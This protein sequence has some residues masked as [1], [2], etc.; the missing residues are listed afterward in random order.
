MR[1]FLLIIAV[2]TTWGAAFADETPSRRAVLPPSYEEVDGIAAVAGDK[3]VTISELRRAEGSHQS[4]QQLVPTDAERPRSKGALRLQTLQSL[5]DNLLV[6]KA[7]KDLGLTADDDDVQA[8]LE[9]TKKRT[10]WTDEELEENVKRLGFSNLAAYKT[11][12]RNELLRMQM[13]KVKLGS[14]LRVTDDEVKRVLELEH[15]GGAYEDEILASHILVEVKADATPLDVARLRDEAWRIHDEV[16][17]GKK[18]FAELA[19]EHSDDAGAEK[20][21]LGWQRRWTLDPTFAGK[22]W[23]MKKGEVSGVV[24]TPFGFHLIQ[25]HDRRQAPVKDKELLQQVV[26]ARL[27]EDQ[28]VR[29]YRAWIEELRAATHV[30]IRVRDEGP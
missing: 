19:Q 21:L 30:E 18:T 28:L 24:Q 14:R 16:K 9:R 5:V 8:E 17:A 25:M 7:A 4:S 27:S 1:R 10:N 12:V 26:R 22:L 6:L 2:L 29:L 20:G 23:S 3:V 15:G 11:N 13:L